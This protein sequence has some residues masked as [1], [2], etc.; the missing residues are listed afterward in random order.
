MAIDIL[1]SDKSIVVCLK[2]AGV[3]SEEAPG[4]MPELLRMELKKDAA[5]PQ[6]FP[7][8]RLDKGVGGVMVYALTKDAA[9]SLTRQMTESAPADAGKTFA[10][11]YLAVTEGV[12][13]PA[14]GRME[15]LLF[16]DR[17]KNR[18]YVVKRPRKG[19]K[20]AVLEYETL[21][22]AGGDPEAG[23][24]SL[25]RI[26]LLTGRTHQIR[27]QFSSRKLPLCGDRRYGAKTAGDIA[28]WSHRLTFRHPETGEEL[29]FRAGPPKD[30]LWAAF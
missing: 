15:D 12:P 30:G 13:E 1:Y 9:A 26:R 2:P 3:V 21:A 19:V 18:T 8:H 6:I 24:V 28:L 11:E 17:E 20:E 22:S 29:T 16:H 27:A 4:G 7:V 10:K 25:V 23:V 14:S 5:V